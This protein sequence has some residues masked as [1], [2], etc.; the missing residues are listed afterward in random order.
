MIVAVED[1]LSESVVRKLIA[2]IRP[3]L[4]ISVVLGKRGR[5]YIQ[6]K[7]RDLNKTAR[8]VP[9]FIL[10]DL[11]RPIPCPFDL[12]NQ[13]LPPFRAP[14]LLVRI[15]VMEVESWVMAHREAFATHLGVP[16]HRI[17][18]DTDAIS[19]PKE[20]V[21]GLARMSKRRNIRDDLV[22]SLG[23]TSAVGPA[24][25]ATLSHFAT[26]TWDPHAAS[27]A[28]S[29]LRRALDRLRAFRSP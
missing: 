24:F 13:W 19:K 7:A 23:S 12:I 18:P 28:S 20:F 10:A 5:G 27:K 4:N 2:V 21:V 3:D 29:S 22:P 14:A 16:L 8:S 11:D 17:P 1:A 15:A 26:E 9:V 6:K 25:N